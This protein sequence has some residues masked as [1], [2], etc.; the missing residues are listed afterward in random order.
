VQRAARG[1]IGSSVEIQRD[2]GCVDPKSLQL[3]EFAQRRVKNVHHKIDVV[4]QCPP[5]SSH[6]LLVMGMAI[7]FQHRLD[8]PFRKCANMCVGRSRR[9]NEVVGRI[10]Q[11]AQVE[12]DNVHRLVVVQSG[13]DATK[14]TEDFSSV[15]GARIGGRRRSSLG[16]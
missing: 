11:T 2:R 1:E 12:N 3:I 9:Q 10:A 4:Q 6:S 16:K 8:H 7:C 15:W 13:G 5:T 14:V